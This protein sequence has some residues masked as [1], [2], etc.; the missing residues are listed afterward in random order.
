MFDWYTPVLLST[1]IAMSLARAPQVL[2][3]AGLN[4]VKAIFDGHCLFDAVR[5]D[6]QI[7]LLHLKLKPDMCTIL[8]KTAMES[9]INI[10]EYVQLISCENPEQEYV[11]GM[12]RCIVNKEYDHPSIIR[13]TWQDILPQAV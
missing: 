7:Q 10:K 8:C 12:K 3:Q 6:Y 9:L 2:Q 11:R 13:N 5:L 4:I 1:C